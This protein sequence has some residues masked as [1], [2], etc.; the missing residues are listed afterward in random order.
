MA[1]HVE[2]GLALG[3]QVADVLRVAVFQALDNLPTVE[4]AVQEIDQQVLVGGSAEYALESEVGQQADVS[5]FCSIHTT[6]Y[7]SAVKI[8]LL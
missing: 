8:Q 2:D 5:F 4:Q 7:I 1:I 6:K 3:I